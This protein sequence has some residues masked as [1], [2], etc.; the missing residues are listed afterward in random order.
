MSFLFF[1]FPFKATLPPSIYMRV[2]FDPELVRSNIPNI[3]VIQQ[4]GR[5]QREITKHFR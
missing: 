4:L 3:M 1:E 2:Q 5:E